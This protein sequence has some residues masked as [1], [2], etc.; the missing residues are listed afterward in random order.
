MKPN[1][2]KDYGKRE[3]MASGVSREARTPDREDKSISKIK[4]S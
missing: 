4:N 1:R 2:N 3:S